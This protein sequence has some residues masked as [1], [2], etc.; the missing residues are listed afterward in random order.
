M[1]VWRL[2]RRW[3]GRALVVGR[4]GFGP[5]FLKA[6]FKIERVCGLILY[7]ALTLG[8]IAAHILGFYMV[9]QQLADFGGKRSK[10]SVVIETFEF[11]GGL[12]FIMN[13][14]DKSLNRL[15]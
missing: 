1:D 3:R 2:G 14:F 15:G 6:R 9:S 13:Y 12:D 4:Q 8:L 11:I 10:L 5:A 7:V